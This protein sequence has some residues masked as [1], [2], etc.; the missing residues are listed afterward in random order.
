[1][2]RKKKI[3]T[4]VA[5]ENINVEN[6]VTEEVKT[7]ETP[8]VE[9]TTVDVKTTPTE[10][11]EETSVEE[12]TEETVTEEI[13]EAPVV[14]ETKDE[15]VVEE[16]PTV[17]EKVEKTVAE[18]PVAEEVPAVEEKNEETTPV[19]VS[20]TNGDKPT[21]EPVEFVPNEDGALNQI[22][23][24]SEE[25]LKASV[26]KAREEFKVE[27]D[28]LLKYNKI[29]GGVLFVAMIAILVVGM[30]Y[31]DA[32]TYL[33]IGIAVYFILVF[34]LT[35]WQ[36]K[37]MDDGVKKYLNVYSLYTES[38]A[39]DP[40]TYK[41]VT[42]KF[43]EKLDKE[44]VDK[45]EYVNDCIEIGSRNIVRYTLNGTKGYT[46][47]VSI[48]TGEKKVRKTHKV[49]FVGKLVILPL[50]L[51]QEG[52][53]L[54]Y[55]K[56]LGDA[57]PSKLDDVNKI[58]IPELSS[59]WSVYASDDSLAKVFTPKLVKELNGLSCDS[60]LNDVLISFNE[61]QL[62]IGLSYSDD[63]MVI[64]LE[65]EFDSTGFNHFRNDMNKVAD[66]YNTLKK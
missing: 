26:N 56:G 33:L 5:S 21:E 11:S 16:V 8:A 25:E 13:S 46:G 61:G 49:G 44:V 32:I 6:P 12:K 34:A 39:Y 45:L 52:R 3:E 37:K 15:P 63:L 53:I 58:D 38:Y 51:K 18:E 10:V 36:R 30:I 48:K 2:P 62:L 54:C 47:D 35:R 41:D 40:S 57:E 65:K 43:E 17:E 66:I 31:P 20:P 24:S 50:E 22:E 60:I 7:E 9:E 59:A 14:E 28:K 64:P 1:M 27:H 19:E 29:L 23:V 4:T 42:I 55:L